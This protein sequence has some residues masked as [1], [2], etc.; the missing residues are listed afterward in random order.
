MWNNFL[1]LTSI[2]GCGYLTFEIIPNFVILIIKQLK[3]KQIVCSKHG[4]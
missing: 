2:I 4:E 1:I 3:L